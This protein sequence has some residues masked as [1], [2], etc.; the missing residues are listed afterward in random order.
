MNEARAQRSR[1]AKEQCRAEKTPKRTRLLV[2]LEFQFLRQGKQ[3]QISLVRSVD[4]K[5]DLHPANE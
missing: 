2:T 3:L 1:I 5:D 4:L